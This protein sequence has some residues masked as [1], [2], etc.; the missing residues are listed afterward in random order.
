MYKFTDKKNEMWNVS[1]DLRHESDGLISE[2][3]IDVLYV[4]NCKFVR[5]TCFDDLNKT[6]DPKCPICFGTGH[7]ASIEKLQ[8]IESSNSAY[9]STNS[10]LQTNIGVTD[11]KNEI[12]YIRH[13]KTP[14]IRDMI[15]KVTWDRDKNP[16][17]IVQVL[18]ITNIYEMRGTNGR[19]ELDGCLINDRTDLVKPFS[20]S[21][22]R[23]TRKGMNQLLKGGKYIWP[24]HLLK[25]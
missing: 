3:G 2:F 17:D 8:C 19:V 1:I 9:S 22:K 15:L 11:E 13:D 5:C 7:F 21:I 6:G 23:L 20:D 18:E 16:V 12:Y 4:R 14:K 25:P 10:L 24:S